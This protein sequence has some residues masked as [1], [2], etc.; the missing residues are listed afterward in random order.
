MLCS[1]TVFGIG[2]K[3]NRDSQ[4]AQVQSG[5]FGSILGAGGANGVDR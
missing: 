5:M 3:L 4:L 2:R 1:D